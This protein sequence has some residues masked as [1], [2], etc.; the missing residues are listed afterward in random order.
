MLRSLSRHLQYYRGIE[1][2]VAHNS[3]E[4]QGGNEL[5]NSDNDVEMTEIDNDIPIMS[6]E[7]GD[8]SGD[9]AGGETGD[10]MNLGDKEEQ[11]EH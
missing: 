4:E 6:V 10:V 2:L 5:E 11:E 8:S 1:E 9:D 3:D 7:G